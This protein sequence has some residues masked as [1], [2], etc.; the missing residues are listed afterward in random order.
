MSG[1]RT[2]AAIPSSH[3]LNAALPEI[4]ALG[5]EGDHFAGGVKSDGGFRRDSW[6]S[7]RGSPE[8]GDQERTSDFHTLDGEAGEMS[9][10]FSGS[11]TFPSKNVSLPREVDCG[12]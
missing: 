3:G 7:H 9:F 8:I 10:G 4:R 5:L 1:G 12:I 6:Q 11:K 2:E